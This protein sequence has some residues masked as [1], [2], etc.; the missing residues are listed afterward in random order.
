[1]YHETRCPVARSLNN[2]EPVA[3]DATRRTQAFRQL[4]AVSGVSQF[5]VEVIHVAPHPRWIEPS[6]DR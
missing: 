5:A 3:K 2:D 1:M 4:Q 6:P